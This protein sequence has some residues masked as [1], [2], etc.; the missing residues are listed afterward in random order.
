MSSFFSKLLPGMQAAAK[1]AVRAFPKADP[2]TPK[3]GKAAA[4]I[5]KVFSDAGSERRGHNAAPMAHLEDSV[6]T[7]WIQDPTDFRLGMRKQS[8]LEQA[9]RLN[10]RLGLSC[11]HS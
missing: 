11:V 2:S 1:P 7:E 5:G 9:A 3:I 10:S 6:A 8:Q 4:A